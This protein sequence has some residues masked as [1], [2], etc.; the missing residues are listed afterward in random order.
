[1]KQLRPAL[2]AHGFTEQQWRVLSELVPLDE[3]AA[4]DLAAATC[5]RASSLSRI[6]KDLESRD[7]ISRRSQLEDL[8]RT[9]VSLTPRGMTTMQQLLPVMVQIYAEIGASYGTGRLH[10][11][12]DLATELVVALGGAGEPDAD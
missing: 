12:T 11:L 5:L 10:T 3:L 8:R 6:I 9:M 1:M 7:L 2:R 4:S